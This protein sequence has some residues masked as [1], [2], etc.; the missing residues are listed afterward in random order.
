MITVEG[1]L[2]LFNKVVVEKIKKEQDVVL[3][4][5]E[6]Q[7]KK[8]LEDQREESTKK[9]DQFL[10]AIID[11]AY[12]DKKAMLAREKSELKRQLLKERQVLIDHLA[13]AVLKRFRAFVDE[14]DYVL[15]LQNLVH[16][17]LND[18]E[19]FGAL[20][21]MLEGQHF[22]R[23]REIV[24]ATLK[25]LGLT[26]G[27]YIESEEDMVGGCIFYNEAGDVLIDGSLASL[28]GEHRSEIGQR[29]Y[30]ML[31]EVGDEGDE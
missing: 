29:L 11:E 7:R 23:D 6:L 30:V 21:V 17:Y 8:L 9:A 31:N 10:K 26:A 15:Y 2:K 4:E 28:I 24:R 1:K 22:E 25:A 5:L 18:L 12:E 16:R 14:P 20:T 27:G 3:K 19:T 13:E